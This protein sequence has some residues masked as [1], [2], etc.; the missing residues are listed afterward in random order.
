MYFF[1]WLIV[2]SW[3]HFLDSLTRIALSQ[4]VKQEQDSRYRTAKT[5]GQLWQAGQDSRDTRV[6][7]GQPEQD[8]QNKTGETRQSRQDSWDRTSWTKQRGQSART[9]VP[10]GSQDRKNKTGRQNV[11]ARQGIWDKDRT[12]GAELVGWDSWNRT[13]KTRQP[14]QGIL[15]KTAGTVHTAK[16][17]KIGQASPNITVR[18]G[19]L[20]QDN[21]DR[22]TIAGKPWQNSWDR[23]SWTEHLGQDIWAGQPGQVNFDR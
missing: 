1:L 22:A 17:W 6:G 7:T 19:Q 2:S 5:G 14:G 23:K 20:G 13:A 10:H 3:Y 16:I 12:A 15:E 21:W 8:S 9:G 18:T 11:T 4:T